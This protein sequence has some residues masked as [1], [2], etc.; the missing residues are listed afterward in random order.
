MLTGHLSAGD[1]MM[2]MSHFHGNVW[3]SPAGHCPL[4][5]PTPR[6]SSISALTNPDPHPLSSG[7]CVVEQLD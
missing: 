7:A 4:N 5:T 1:L 2:M 3:T 6:D